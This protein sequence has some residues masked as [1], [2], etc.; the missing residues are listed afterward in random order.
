MF[1]ELEK[2]IKTFKNN[3]FGVKSTL[4]TSIQ[5]LPIAIFGENINESVISAAT[6]TLTNIGVMALSQLK[7]GEM[8]QLV[9]QSENGYVVVR[10]AED[11]GIV[12]VVA[13]PNTELGYLLFETKNLARTVAHLL[14]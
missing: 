7:R 10:T 9:L 1:A 13:D 14:P 6:A 3:T 5:G 4:I 8:Q 2:T 12:T 11:K